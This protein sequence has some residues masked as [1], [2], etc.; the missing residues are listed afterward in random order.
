MTRASCAAVP[1]TTVRELRP[2]IDQF[3]IVA[4]DGLWDVFQ[5]REAVE[6][7]AAAMAEASAPQQ[8]RGGLRLASPRWIATQ[9]NAVLQ[10]GRTSTGNLT[11]ASVLSPSLAEL[12]METV[13][14]VYGVRR[15]QVIGGPRLV[16]LRLHWAA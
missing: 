15:G 8:L 4:S 12:E 7:A 9:G 11:M 5:D 10:L 3:V 16:E 6:F 1:D 13:Q 14:G 2:D